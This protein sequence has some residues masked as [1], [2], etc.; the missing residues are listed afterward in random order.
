[1]EHDKVKKSDIQKLINSLNNPTTT[2]PITEPVGLFSRIFNFFTGGAPI[3]TSP[4]SPLIT[5]MPTTTS[6]PTNTVDT[7]IQAPSI[8]KYLLNSR[9]QTKSSSSNPQYTYSPSIYS[10]M[11]RQN[12]TK[13]SSSQANNLERKFKLANS[14]YE[15]FTNSNSNSTKITEAELITNMKKNNENIENVAIAFVTIIILLFLLVIFNAIRNKSG[16]SK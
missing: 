16:L 5:T 11:Y 2:N 8:P 9:Q 7:S 12:D 6:I 4:N 15:H 13:H 1:M 3:T 10:S 14:T